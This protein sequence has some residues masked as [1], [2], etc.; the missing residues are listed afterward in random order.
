MSS[1][2]LPSTTVTLRSV[3]LGLL[4]VIGFTVAGCFSVLL[5]YE[6]IG[7][8][9]LPRGAVAVLLLLVIANGLLGALVRRLRLGRNEVLLIFVMLLAM[10][11]IPGQDFAQHFYL[12]L[13]GVVYYTT[14]DIAGPEVYLD[15]LNPALFPSVD[16][17]APVIRWAFEGLP[18][19]A[20]FPFRPWLGPLAIWTPYLL[21]VYWMLL[22]AAAILSARWENHEK[23]LFPL[24][25]V[26]NE[27]TEQTSRALPTLLRNK[28]MWICFGL[29]CLLYIIKGLHT[30][31]PAIPDIN[32][33]RTTERPFGGGP[34]VVF[35]NVPLHLYPEV[36]GISYLLTSE[37]GFSLWFFYLFRLLQDFTRRLFGLTTSS[38]AFFE[39]QT[40]GS[41]VVM[42]LA[43]LWSARKYLAEVFGYALGLRAPPAGET[44]P[45]MQR[46]AAIGFIVGLLFV[47]YWATQVGMALSWALLLFGFLP[48]T[49]MVVSR[50]ICEAGMSIYSPPFRLNELIFR[51]VGS[52]VIGAQNVALMTAASWVQVRST[53]TQ[54]MPQAF[55]GLKLGSMGNLNRL[56]VLVLMMVAVGV[57]ILT[58]HVA[59]PWIIYSWGVPKLG[60]WPRGSSLGT[61]KGLVS[62]IAN[63]VDMRLEDWIGLVVGGGLSVLLVAMRQRF[64]WWPFHPAGYVAWLGWPIDRYWLSIF[65]GWLSK[66]VVLRFFGYKVF[67]QLRPAAF[68]LILGIC[69][70]LT[71]WLVFHFFI[72]GPPLLVE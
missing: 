39:M 70:I 32:L 7:T 43:L 21:A 65:L 22:C 58:C 12:N 61:T 62:A 20:P 37:V 25:Q 30:Y 71:F 44:Q 34:A 8:S 66:T 10:A 64:L 69:F 3:V 33:Q 13:V 15:G 55:Q 23:L 49:G 53:A 11:A 59:A 67:A 24:M 6:I 27:M 63:P 26:P 9:Y 52:D 40:A 36:I 68:G 47:L 14:P 31:F 17:E 16:R 18:P 60:W 41:Y 4:L 51:V 29:S 1:P 19:G 28:G 48:L 35:N 50:V 46:V 42:G 5:R 72:E 56:H 54:F 45:A 38:Y 2:P 57:A